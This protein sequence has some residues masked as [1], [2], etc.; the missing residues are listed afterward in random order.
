MAD[1]GGARAEAA[2]TQRGAMMQLVIVDDEGQTTIVPLVRDEVLIGRAEEATIRLTQRN[3]SR[4]HARVYKDRDGYAIEDLRSTYGTYLNGA[5]IETTAPLS[6]DDEVAIGDYRIA[7]R[8][9]GAGPVVSD[10]SSRLSEAERLAL[11]ARLVLLTQPAPGAEFAIPE[12]I[13]C[14]G[15]NE[16][17]PVSI[18]HRSVAPVHAELR[19]AGG[20]VRIATLDS[21]QGIRVNGEPVEI[22]TLASGDAIDLGLVRLKYVGPGEAHRFGVCEVRPPAVPRPRGVQRALLA[23]AA[24]GVGLVIGG[25]AGL[26]LQGR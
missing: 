3:V 13:S 10:G 25:G 19:C 7:V 14:V 4:R 12:G 18:A 8:D 15:R 5:R 26:W 6:G 22:A 20:E 17:L 21:E 11:P 2:T 1:R 9:E 23:I 24:L 16:G